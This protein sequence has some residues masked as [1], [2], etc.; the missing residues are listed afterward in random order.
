LTSLKV[1]VLYLT[2]V[3]YSNCVQP[4]G[5][6]DCYISAYNC[7]WSTAM[8]DQML[9]DHDA[10]TAGAYT[11]TLKIDGSNDPHTDPGPAENARASLVLKGKTVEVN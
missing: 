7:D 5:W 1:L 4:A 8:V 2:D 9:I 10:I 11:S 6:K 3:T